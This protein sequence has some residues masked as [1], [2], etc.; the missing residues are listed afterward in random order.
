MN[1]ADKEKLA[2][3]IDFNCCNHSGNRNKYFLGY[4]GFRCCKTAMCLDC[5]K[6]Q[7]VGGS[8]GKIIYRATRCIFRRRFEILE[9]IEIEPVFNLYD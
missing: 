8:V 1:D 5:D 3:R 9:T 6:I 2:N 4:V 7:F